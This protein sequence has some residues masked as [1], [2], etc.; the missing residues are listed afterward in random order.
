MIWL[1]ALPARNSPDDAAG[2]G[3]CV[4]H[5]MPGFLGNPICDL[6]L[7]KAMNSKAEKVAKKIVTHGETAKDIIALAVELRRICG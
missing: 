4:Q 6:P 3:G 2:S 7:P 5:A 1:D